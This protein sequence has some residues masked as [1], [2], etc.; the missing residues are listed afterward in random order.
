MHRIFLTDL[1]YIYFSTVCF[2]STQC[3]FTGLVSNFVYITSPSQGAIPFMHNLDDRHSRECLYL[4]TYVIK[5][6]TT[7][8]ISFNI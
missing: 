7:L 1:S 3:G 2:L 5:G 6:I 4:Y 8:N